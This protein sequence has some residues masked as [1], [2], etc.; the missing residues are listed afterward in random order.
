MLSEKI[1]HFAKDYRVPLLGTGIF[2][3]ILLTIILIRTYEKSALADVL[4][5]KTSSTQDYAT[6]LSNDKADKFNK[7]NVSESSPSTNNNKTQIASNN[8]SSSNTSSNAPSN[9]F[10]DTTFNNTTVNSSESTSTNPAPPPASPTSP[11]PSQTPPPPPFSV[12]IT[13]MFE[14]TSQNPRNC[15]DQVCQETL[16]FKANLAA[17]NGP[18]VIQYMWGWY[19]CPSSVTNCSASS[20]PSSGNHP[21]SISAPTGSSAPQVLQDIMVTCQKGQNYV[22]NVQFGVSSPN[23]T[24]TG[25]QHSFT[26]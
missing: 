6:L 21:G 13:N 22:L 4:P 14:D 26:C 16:N 12:S 1:K 15:S 25:R 19:L 20:S 9:T 17:T 24:S 7:N 18:G 11:P 23:T 3:A 10:T 2:V 5:R 8:P